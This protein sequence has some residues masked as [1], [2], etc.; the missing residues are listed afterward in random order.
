MINKILALAYLLTYHPQYRFARI[1][2]IIIESQ[3]AHVQWFNHGCNTIMEE[4]A[5]PQELFLSHRCD[6]YSLHH[7]VG[8]V[9][10]FML[11]D[12]NTIIMPEDY[13]CK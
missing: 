1:L 7:V 5:H 6:T 10:V 12:A 3:T 4:L 13:F 9:T 2:Y 11:P 8:K